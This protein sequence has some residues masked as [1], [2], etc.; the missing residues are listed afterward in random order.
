M[1]GVTNVGGNVGGDCASNF[2]SNLGCGTVY[3]LNSEGNRKGLFDFPYDP[4]SHDYYPYGAYPI[5]T[6]VQGR[7][8]QFYGVTQGGTRHKGF[9][10]IFKVNG[11]GQLQT[12]HVFCQEPDCADGSFPQG[13]LIRGTDGFFYGATI[14]RSRGGAVIYRIAPGGAYQI[15]RT[16][17]R[18]GEGA[19]RPIGNLLQ[20]SDGNFYG[21]SATSTGVGKIFR[22][23]PSG[24]IT[25]FFDFANQPDDGA[26]PT[27]SLIQATD[28]NLYGATGRGG[29]NGA[30]T[31]FRIS[32]SGEY[33]KIFDFEFGASG[34]NPGGP[35]QASDGNLWGT[36]L[37][38]GG[39]IYSVT[40]SGTL[41][42]D[43]VIECPLG[44][45]NTETFT[46]AVNG[47]LYTS[48]YGC[49]G[50][51]QGGAIIQVDAGLPPPSPSIAAF[52]PAS[53]PVG[54]TVVLSGTHFV[55][56]SSVTFNGTPATFV[57]NAAGVVSATVPDGASSGPIQIVGPG[58]TATSSSSFTVTP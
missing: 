15:V 5:G 29:A 16:L 24:K 17:P 25:T 20:A 14:G 44:G 12:L 32:L 40:L 8:S 27:G 49:E 55:S 35:M 31:L 42:Q 57:V 33:S 30:G 36:T 46:Q 43:I 28:G 47:K 21:Y 11:S 1:I 3:L 50:P 13:S 53:G 52:T 54:T 18:H 48:V 45:A 23:T 19:V 9:G 10:T 38:N 37:G 2:G 56:A 34:N 41:L 22:L 39:R 4:Q 6:L 51:G 26:A 58:G 7:D